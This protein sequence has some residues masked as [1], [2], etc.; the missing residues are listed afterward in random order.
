MFYEYM[1]MA[2]SLFDNIHK[3]NFSDGVNI[4]DNNNSSTANNGKQL[5][6]MKG[7]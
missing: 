1:N 3:S 7:N 6:L 5:I 2:L 4:M